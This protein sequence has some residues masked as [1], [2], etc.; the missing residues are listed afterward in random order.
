[1]DVMTVIHLSK[2]TLLRSLVENMEV[3][4]PHKVFKESVK[5]SLGRYNDA[6]ITD[7]L[8]REGKI[9][10]LDVNVDR[11]KEIERFGMTGGEAEAVALYMDGKYDAIASDDVVRENRTLL[12]LK[13]IGTPS[14]VKWMFE[15]G[16]IAKKKAVEGLEELKKISWF[17]RG[18]LDR[19]IAE[20]EIDE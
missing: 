6:L 11:I 2:I 12:N 15:E 14:I 4:I 10:V 3:V 17:E 9:M 8:I 13:V 5:D 7:G 19:I 16:I 18:L 1:M 20:V